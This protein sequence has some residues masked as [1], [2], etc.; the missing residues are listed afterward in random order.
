MNPMLICDF[1]KV[2]HMEQYPKGTQLIH[3]TWTPRFSITG[4]FEEVA[5]FGIQAF[6]KEWLIDYFNENFFK[7]PIE[8][9]ISDYVRTV[10]YSLGRVNPETE[11]IRKLHALGYLPLKVM[12]LKEGTLSS[13][14]VPILTIENTMP[15]YFWLTNYLETL[16]STE[17][18]MATTS[19][20]TSYEYKKIM[21]RYKNLTGDTSDDGTQVDTM[22]HNFSMR[23]MSGVDAGSKSG[24]AHLIA[25][26]GTDTIPAIYWLEKYYNANIEKELVGCSIPS[27]EH[28]VMTAYGSDK[29]LESL[30][31]LMTEVYPDGMFSVV[32]DSWDFWK[33]IREY[34]PILKETIMGREGKV[35]IRPDSGIPEDILC[36]TVRT[37]EGAT[38]PEERGLI[39]CLWDIFGGTVNDQGYKVLDGHIGAI[40]G[41]S[42][43]T[44]RAEEILERLKDK[45]FAYNNIVFGVGSYSFQYQTRDTLGFA[46]KS[47]YAVINGVEKLLCKNPK[48]D[49]GKRSQRGRVCVYEEGGR[50][51]YEDGLY[52]KD[53][54]KREKNL[55]ETVFFNGAL[56]R[57]QS[58]KEIRERLKSYTR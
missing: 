55:L 13:M 23:G 49:T 20:T 17:L 31:L 5:V 3:S 18:W 26:C 21:N 30:R 7:A 51:K 27:T 41:D 44:E 9:I 56:M 47:T 39:Q 12:A 14:G 45:G 46:M 2:C 38:T 4:K 19:A 43:T 54:E 6:I 42:I 52:A 33:V 58:L 57:E 34:L 8:D 32:V 16:I 22:C 35:I 25:F 15:E 29:E 48:T 53:L 24:A 40:Y 1:Y 10:R 36:G 50:T 37:L 28:S 11:H